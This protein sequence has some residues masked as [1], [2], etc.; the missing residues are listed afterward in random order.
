LILIKYLRAETYL[1]IDAIF[2]ILHLYAVIV[3]VSLC[4]R[5]FKN[6]EL[7]KKAPLYLKYA[8]KISGKIF[9]LCRSLQALFILKISHFS[10][11]D[12]VILL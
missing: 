2:I 10:D 1:D 9:A 8:L 11:A 7:S 3:D 6:K 12:S 5:F 4:K